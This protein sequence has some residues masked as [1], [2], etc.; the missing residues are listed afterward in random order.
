M[1]KFKPYRIIKTPED[2]AMLEKWIEALRSGEFKQTTHRLQDSQG[3][4]CLGVACEL[5]I[6]EKKKNKTNYGFLSRSLPEYQEFAPLFLKLINDDFT[7]ITREASNGLEVG[8]SLTSLNDSLGFDFNEISDILQ[9]VY[10][11]RI[12]E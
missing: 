1:K 5:L 9:A 7:E 12:F 4:C 10:I 11:E 8:Q 3:Y 2:L 6:P